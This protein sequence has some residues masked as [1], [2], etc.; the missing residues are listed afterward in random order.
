MIVELK[1]VIIS[2]IQVS[3]FS[4]VGALLAWVYMGVWTIG[5]Y[6]GSILGIAV[7]IASQSD[8]S[9]LITEHMKRLE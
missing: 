3:L 4:F 1:K 8:T 7:F 2:F 6:W 9:P 5:A